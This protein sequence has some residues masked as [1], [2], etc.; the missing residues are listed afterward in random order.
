MSAQTVGNILKRHGLLPAPKR[1]TTTWTE[2]IH[3]R[4]DMLVAT[5]FFAA[6]VWTLG[7]L[8]TAEHFHH[9]HNHQ[10]KGTVLLFPAA[11][12]TQVVKARFSVANGSWGS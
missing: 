1:Q 5:D 11:A 10:G 9:E 6:E 3:T 7:G 2:F 12:K 8:V 4:L